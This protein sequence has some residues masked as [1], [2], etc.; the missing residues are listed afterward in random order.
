MNLKIRP[1]FFEGVYRGSVYAYIYR[2]EC[3]YVYKYLCLYCVT[4]EKKTFPREAVYDST[5]SSFPLL[6]LWLAPK[7]Y[8]NQTTKSSLFS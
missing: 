6:N 8:A 5:F 7:I 4:Y 2:G 1:S 3:S